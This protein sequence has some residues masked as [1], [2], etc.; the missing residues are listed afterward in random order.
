MAFLPV[1]QCA[2]CGC[3]NLAAAILR[4]TNARLPPTAPRAAL[5]PPLHRCHGVCLL[6]AAA[7]ATART[8]SPT[9]SYAAAAARCVGRVCRVGR[10]RLLSLLSLSSLSP[11]LSVP[12]IMTWSQGTNTT[13]FTPSHYTKAVPKS[14][15]PLTRPSSDEHGPKHGCSTS[16]ISLDIQ[17]SSLLSQMS[18]GGF[19][20][21]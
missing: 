9:A 4:D 16:L 19:L 1:G 14:T 15:T 3:W 6:P 18:V 8:T 2:C 12:K 5:L 13:I 11:P 10:R 21:P 7:G 20:Q 17:S